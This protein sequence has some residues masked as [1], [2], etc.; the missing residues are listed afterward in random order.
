MRPVTL[1]AWVGGLYRGVGLLLLLAF[2]AL[3]VA[4]TFLLP[5]FQV[6][7]ERRHWLA[8][9][10]HL[11]KLVTGSGTVCST[12][13]SIVRHFEVGLEFHPEV[14]LPEGIF[15]GLE[16]LEP[17]C[18]D[19]LLYTR[20][21]VASYP[22]V[23]LSRLFVPREP[24]TGRQ[25]L[26]GFYLSRLLNGA[27]VTLMLWRLWRLARADDR[28][29]PLLLL[30]LV[31][32]LSPLFVQQAFGVTND[33]VP[34]SFA[35]AVCGWVAFPDRHTRWS[36][37]LVLSLGLVAALT[38]PMLSIPLLPAVAFGLYLERLRADPGNPQPLFRSLAEAFEQHRPF[39]IGLV[40]VSLA[41]LVYVSSYI[42]LEKS[43]PAGQFAFVLEHPGHA[44]GVIVAKFR[45]F[46]W[47]P[48]VFI[49][50]LGYMTTR[51]GDG[52]R[53]CFAGLLAI[54]GVVELTLIGT[55]IRSAVGRPSI[56][57]AYKAVGLLALLVIGSLIV[58]AFAIGI[59]QYL[60][61][62]PIGGKR[63]Y[64]MQPRYLFPHWIVGLGLA[65]ALARTWLPA[66]SSPLAIGADE[67]PA[68]LVL[69]VGGAVVIG[70]TVATLLAFGVQLATDLLARYS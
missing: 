47:H 53:A 61:A 60:V 59:R 17:A 16:T 70:A 24:T 29:P 58:S 18:Q 21:N 10:H 64:G 13:V 22:G 69:R 57:H 45:T 50:N 20:G 25:A 7:D 52:T 5:P 33:V 26:F 12:D 39:L 67:P 6:P 51:I 34:L 19:Q 31:L 44:M 27:L 36:E 3:G 30:L 15:S 54:V 66:A 9:H 42:D 4:N 37:A 14:K 56:R 41:G 1:N 38:K 28:G 8:A 40:A 55:Q 63:L 49:D 62:S 65:L 11:A 35:L 48:T 43:R 2:G 68:P 23:V 32:A 46:F